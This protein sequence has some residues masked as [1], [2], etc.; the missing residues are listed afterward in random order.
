MDAAIRTS[1]AHWI[2]WHSTDDLASLGLLPATP[3]AGTAAVTPQ[4]SI[5]EPAALLEDRRS[6]LD[7]H[8]SQR[9][10]REGY[11]SGAAVHDDQADREEQ[12]SLLT[13]RLTSDQV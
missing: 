11:G 10:Q 5:G 3:P 8:G 7:H 2:F 12:R 4:P 1:P 6:A 9:G 13:E